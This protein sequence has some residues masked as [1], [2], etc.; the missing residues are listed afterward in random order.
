MDIVCPLTQAA[1]SAWFLMR[2]AVSSIVP[3]AESLEIVGPCWQWTIYGESLS[4]FGIV[5]WWVRYSVG[6]LHP[7]HVGLLWTQTAQLGCGIGR[8]CPVIPPAGIVGVLLSRCRTDAALE[9][10]RGETAVNSLRGYPPC[11]PANLKAGW[12]WHSWPVRH[13]VFR[14]LLLPGKNA[15]REHEKS[16]KPFVLSLEYKHSFIFRPQTQ[17]VLRPTP[18]S[19][20]SE[21]QPM[22]IVRPLERFLISWSVQP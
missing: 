17:V 18:V 15:K 10:V 2:Q 19:L 9:I 22:G 8:E 5:G 14:P 13:P 16:S 6:W 12:V 1:V 20:K 3:A 11:I 4:L 21:I 7:A